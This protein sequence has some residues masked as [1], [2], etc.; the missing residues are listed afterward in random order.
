MCYN[1][2]SKTL[3]LFISRYQSS[4]M[5]I[6]DT[7]DLNNFRMNDDMATVQQS[8]WRSQESQRC[9]AAPSRS[10]VPALVSLSLSV[11]HVLL[12]QGV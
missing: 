2:L 4:E 8:C 11:Y 7:S 3:K 1:T 9:L 10:Q 5:V 12:G 6:V